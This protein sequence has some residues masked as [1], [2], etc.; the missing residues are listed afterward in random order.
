MDFKKS[1]FEIEKLSPRLANKVWQFA[2]VVQNPELGF[3]WRVISYTDSHV[4]AEFSFRGLR[5]GVLAAGEK[6][7]QMLWARHLDLTQA[8]L[9]LKIIRAEFVKEDEPDCRIRCELAEVEREAL[10]SE[11]WARKQIECEMPAVILNKKGQT[12]ALV[13]M[14][15]EI[16]W[17]KTA[18]LLSESK[19]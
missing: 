18:G 13:H 6:C 5:S 2:S 17:Q 1:L 11:L 14:Q 3:D 16:Q 9:S 4:E 15:F 19:E 12:L 8:K 7:A 10:L